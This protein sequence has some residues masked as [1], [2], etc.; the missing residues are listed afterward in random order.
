MTDFNLLFIPFWSKNV[1]NAKNNFWGNM[2]KWPRTS[3]A[4]ENFEILNFSRYS[5]Y[6][7]QNR[8]FWGR[9]IDSWGQFL[10][11]MKNFWP[12]EATPSF[13]PT[14]ITFLRPYF[15]CKYGIKIYV[16]GS[17]KS[18]PGVDVTFWQRDCGLLRPR[19]FFLPTLITLSK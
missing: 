9:R 7:Y 5:Q 18:I 17:T 12:S 3:L 10:S 13:F 11:K 19:P 4:W 14:L 2:P 6:M 15:G 1:H 8:G 16:F